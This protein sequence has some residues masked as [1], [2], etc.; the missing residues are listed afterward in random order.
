[1]SYI[2]NIDQNID[3]LDEPV[4]A[5]I[6]TLDKRRKI[7]YGET[8]IFRAEFRDELGDLYDPV[9][10]G[11]DLYRSA[12]R[13]MTKQFSFLAEE[14]TRT[15]Q[16]IFQISISIPEYLVPSM[17]TARWQTEHNGDTVYGLEQFFV[18][19]PPVDNQDRLDPPRISG[20][21]R[22]SLNYD[23]MGEGTTDTICLIGH[24]DGLSV[25]DPYQ[26]ADLQEAVDLLQANAESPLLR[27]LLEAYGSGCRDIWLVA[28]APMREYVALHSD[29]FEERDEW[30]GRNFY[31]RYAQRLSETYKIVR[32]YDTF[33]VIISLEAPFHDAGGVDFFT[34]LV[35]LCYNIFIL[36][37]SPP[38]GVI[39]TRYD[40][41]TQEDI[42]ALASDARIT[43]LHEDP[44]YSSAA[45]MVLVAFGEAF[46]R[47]PF[48]D[49]MH[50]G[51]V[52]VAAASYL[53]ANAL[54]RGLSYTP[55]QNVL[56]IKGLDLEK[57]QIKQLSNARL[58]PVVRT[59]EGKRG[60]PFQV[61]LA[62]DN[63]MAPEGSDYWSVV[64]MRLVSRVIKDIKQ[65]GGSYIGTIQYPQFVNALK[66][67][68]KHLQDM[69]YLRDYTFSVERDQNDRGRVIVD[70][71][72]YPRFGI[73]D[74]RFNVE[75]GPET[76]VS[77]TT[78]YELIDVADPVTTGLDVDLPDNIVIIG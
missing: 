48:I 16:G 43:S 71:V 33:D 14:I 23:N 66:V 36:T 21:I 56:T 25:N 2:D 61:V 55:L 63:T 10:V 69:D 15:S 44:I 37:G 34:P 22:E 18:V 53:C 27:A 51:S 8:I 4:G 29:R 41:I 40:S 74:I 78:A 39:G 57:D 62:T 38:I 42:D 11:F 67:Y 49:R 76:P 20:V 9:E 26:V 24:V 19:D 30:G 1:M 35:H 31:E 77:M 75:V 3:D 64:Q 65:L 59:S 6:R 58:N 47:S 46:I 60:V 54:V 68:F 7:V 73:N 12:L 32:Q 70:V 45:K 52:D 50:P 72:L 5:I 17:Y 13:P 28:A